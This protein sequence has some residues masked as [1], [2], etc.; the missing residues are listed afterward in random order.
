M[1]P[2]GQRTRTYAALDKLAIYLKMIV[3]LS[4]FTPVFRDYVLH[5]LYTNTQIEHILPLRTQSEAALGLY[6]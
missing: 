6:L 5:S 2:V 1:C 4:T 3:I